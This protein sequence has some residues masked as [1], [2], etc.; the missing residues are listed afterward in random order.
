LSLLDQS[1]TGLRQLTGFLRRINSLTISLGLFS[2]STGAKPRFTTEFQN[3]AKAAIANGYREENSHQVSSLLKSF[4]ASAD[5]GQSRE[6]EYLQFYENIPSFATLASA[7]KNPKEQRNMLPFNPLF[8]IQDT[9]LNVTLFSQGSQQPT[10]SQSKANASESSRR[11][12]FVIGNE[13]RA[14]AQQTEEV[15]E[16]ARNM[17]GGM[18]SN[19]VSRFTAS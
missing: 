8:T 9:Y 3:R 6:L 2:T 13:S 16:K 12:V 4:E 11:D 18:V 5:S 19:L 14:I 15:L 10:I 17:V 7:R 1:N